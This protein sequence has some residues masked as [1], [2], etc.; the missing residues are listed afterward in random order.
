MNRVAGSDAV[1]CAD[2]RSVGRPLC[3][4]PLLIVV[5][6]G[7][8]HGVLVKDYEGLSGVCLLVVLSL[9]VRKMAIICPGNIPQEAQQQRPGSGL[10]HVNGK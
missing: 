1:A 8:I 2:L 6:G 4:I 5:F 9:A 10:L 7:N 3:G